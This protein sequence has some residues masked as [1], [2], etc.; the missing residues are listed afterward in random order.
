MIS[1]FLG[2][3]ILLLG[4]FVYSKYLANLFGVEPAR[5]TPAVAHEDGVDFVPLPTWKVFLIQLLNIAGLG[6]IFGAIQGALF[7]PIAFIW[8]ALGSVFAGAVHDYL[9]GMMSL[10]HKGTSLSE[11]QGMYLGKGVQ[12]VMRFFTI[13][14]MVLVGVVFVTGPAKLLASLTPDSFNVTFWVIVVFAY[15]FLA[16][17]LP[18]DALI[19]RLYPIFGIALVVMAVGVGGGIILGGYQIPE[20]TLA[21]LHPKQLPIF[22]MLFITI[23]CGAISGFHATQSPMMARC[24]KNEKYGRPVFYG[25]MIS[26]GI[27]AMVWAAAGMAFYKGIPGLADALVAGGPGGAVH[28][29]TT[30]LLGPIGGLL[31]MLGV[32]ACPIT[33]GDTAFRSARLILTDT[34]KLNQSTTIKRLAV[35]LPLF[36]VGISMTFIN[37]DIIWRYFAWGNQ[38]L[39]AVTLWA[40]SVYLVRQKANHW[41]T[42]IPALLMTSVCTSYILQAKEGFKLAASLSNIVG[43]TVAILCLVLFMVRGKKGVEPTA[44]IEKESVA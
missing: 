8:I 24:M 15:Y 22:P 2:I 27:I 5:L 25:A 39:A 3:I 32:I 38:T 11:I 37:F 17:I 12:Q 21:N 20:I 29:I 4:Y 30:T 9:S 31:A 19:G 33:S 26:E 18:I 10:R 16:T 43:V 1:F 40:I 34:F 42:T 7:G 28:Q 44:V 23:A 14:M 41:V 35:A 13:L 36:A 6:P